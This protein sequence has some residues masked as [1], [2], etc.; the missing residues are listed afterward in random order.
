ML[1]KVVE[2]MLAFGLGKMIEIEME[3]RGEIGEIGKCLMYLLD[4]VGTR[5]ASLV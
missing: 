1:R 5:R 3:M 4:E 2:G